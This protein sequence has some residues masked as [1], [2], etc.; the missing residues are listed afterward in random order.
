MSTGAVAAPSADE[1][2]LPTERQALRF[3]LKLGMISFGGP[4]GQIAIMHEELVERRRW[5]SERRYL[6]ALNFCMALPGPEAQQLATYVGYSM[7]GVR[8]GLA[9]GGLFVLPS[10]VLLCALSAVYAAYGEVAVVDGAVRGLGAAVVALILAAV[11]RIGGRVIRTPAALVLAGGSFAGFVAGVP[12]PALIAL[13]ALIGWCATRWWPALLGPPPAHG[14]AEP[15]IADPLAPARAPRRRGALAR[16]GRTLVVWLVPVLALLLV[17]G[18]VADLAGLFTVAALVT[19]GGAY[20]VLPFITDQAVS[21]F[22]WLSTQDMVAGLALGE[23]TPGPLIMVNTFVGFMAGWNLQGGLL[24]GLI[25]ASI[26][27][28]ATFAPSFVFIINGAPLI[29][30]IRTTG[31]LAGALGG[32]TIAVV[33]AIAALGLFVAEHALV[34][35]DRPDWLVVALTLAA[36]VALWRFKVSV[37]LVVLACAGAGIVAATPW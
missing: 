12:F 1:V 26:A 34:V 35:D 23:S 14:P 7:H 5:I 11:V 3:W 27:T 32:I 15:D 17:G 37:V 29:D 22:G 18:L 19:F 6:H 30:R 13:A 9:A 10:F 28:F 25:G 21:G 24:W 16:L 20:A 4:A 36:F 31:A 33:G 8:G 2:V